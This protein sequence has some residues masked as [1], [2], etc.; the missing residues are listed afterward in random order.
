MNESKIIWKTTFYLK[1][2]EIDDLQKDA[3][4]MEL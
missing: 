2:L 3:D 1:L 4:E